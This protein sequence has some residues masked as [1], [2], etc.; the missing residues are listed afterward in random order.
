LNNAPLRELFGRYSHH[1]NLRFLLYDRRSRGIDFP[2]DRLSGEKVCFFP[3]FA[4]RARLPRLI[5]DGFSTAD[6]AIRSRACSRRSIS[7]SI[8][9]MISSWSTCLTY[10]IAT[11]PKWRSARP[12]KAA[13]DFF[14]MK[15]TASQLP[16]KLFDLQPH[17]FKQSLSHLFQ[18]SVFS[19]ARDRASPPESSLAPKFGRLS[20]CRQ[21][22]R[23]SVSNMM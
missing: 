4:V 19:N 17:T 1:E 7:A 3:T 6:W 2:L 5:L 10:Q 23:M 8:A 16:L 21:T 18:S 22:V 12:P 15:A 14:V 13:C 11:P 9:A 20:N